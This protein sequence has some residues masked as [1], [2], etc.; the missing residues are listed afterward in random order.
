MNRGRTIRGIAVVTACA[1][2]VIAASL[3]P[4]AV[5]AATIRIVSHSQHVSADEVHIAGEVINDG[6]RNADFIEITARL[7]DAS[8]RQL[9]SER[10]YTLLEIVAPGEKTPFHLVFEPPAGYDHYSL[11]VSGT[12]TSM[13]PN[14]N[15]TVRVTNTTVDEFGDRHLQGE[16]TNNNETRAEGVQ[17]VFTFYDERGTVVEAEFTFPEAADF[18]P[19]L[20]AGE[21]A[22]FELTLSSDIPEYSTFAAVAESSSPP[23][24]GSSPSPTASPSAPSEQVHPRTITLAIR[25]HVLA[26]GRVSVGDDF[27]ACAEEVGVLLQRRA[28]GRWRAVASTRTTTEGTYRK[29]LPDRPGRY[30]AVAPAFDAGTA[31]QAHTCARSVSPARAHRH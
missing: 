6:T 27:T 15:F 2:A 29:R 10:A 14:H 11:G 17:I 19:A 21:S 7:L 12:D 9:G 31:E 13:A 1:T 3:L 25:R 16:V 24:G 18:D 5:A 8:N 22:P 26:K 4:E 23:T 28:A 30:R 20:D